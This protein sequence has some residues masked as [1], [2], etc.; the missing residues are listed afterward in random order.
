VVETSDLFH[1]SNGQLVR[2]EGYPPH[3]ERFAG[4]GIDLPA[5]LRG[6]R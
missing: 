4:A 2:G 1:L 5:L 6:D 3:P